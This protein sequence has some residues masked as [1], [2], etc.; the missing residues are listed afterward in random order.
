MRSNQQQKQKSIA[1]VQHNRH[2]NYR[3][4]SF[5]IVEH[6]KRLFAVLKILNNNDNNNKNNNLSLNITC[7]QQIK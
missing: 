2:P 3:L 4:E 7:R 1:L 5:F 6:T